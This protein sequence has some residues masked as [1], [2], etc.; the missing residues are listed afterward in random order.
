[1]TKKKPTKKRGKPGPSPMLTPEL[2]L[3]IKEL[4]LQGFN[5]TQIRAKLKI[6]EDTWNGWN[7][8]DVNDFSSN[9]DKW[10]RI[11]ML[12]ASEQTLHEIAEMDPHVIAM[13]PFGPIIDKKTKKP[14]IKISTSI[15]KIKKDTAEYLTETLA[16]D[17]YNKKTKVEHDISDPLT[18][19]FRKISDKK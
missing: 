19:L 17:T 6:K 7:Y 15:L 16:S 12:K 14:Y 5:Y 4:V 2:S 11:R 10:K 3:K 1:M 8:R 9:L 18:Q 13:G